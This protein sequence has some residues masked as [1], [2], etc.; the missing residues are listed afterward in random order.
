MILAGHPL[1]SRRVRILQRGRTDTQPWCLI[2][3]PTRKHFHYRIPARWLSTEAV[4]DDLA[5]PAQR[6]QIGLNLGALARLVAFANATAQGAACGG[7]GQAGPQASSEKPASCV[8]VDAA[9]KQ[10]GVGGQNGTRSASHGE[11]GGEP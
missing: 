3:D 6:R 10:R 8:A 1:Y 7:L 11:R 2:E 9:E 4:P 5:N